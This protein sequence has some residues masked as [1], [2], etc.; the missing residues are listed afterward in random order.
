M[1]RHVGI[2]IGEMKS[3]G[4]NSAAAIGGEPYSKPSRVNDVSNK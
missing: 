1:R 2:A 3:V 4:D